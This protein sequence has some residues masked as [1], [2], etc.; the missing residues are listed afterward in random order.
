MYVT[1]AQ[2][3]RELCI[4]SFV[5]LL[6]V[7]AA[8][9][10]PYFTSS[11]LARVLRLVLCPPAVY[12]ALTLY[13]YHR[14]PEK[15]TGLNFFVLGGTCVHYACLSVN[16]AFAKEPCWRIVDAS[17]KKK[18]DDADVQKDNPAMLEDP[19]APTRRELVGFA[20]ALVGS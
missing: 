11:A 12:T 8:L 1:A 9:L 15:D 20:F 5:L 16:F 18:D 3:L 7:Q 6:H 14:F 4:W 13:Q 17:A 19:V 2:V 10:H